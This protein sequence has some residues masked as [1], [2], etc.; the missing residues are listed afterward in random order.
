MSSY[1]PV[2]ISKPTIQQVSLELRDLLAKLSKEAIAQR[3]KFTVAFSGGS[4]PTTVA[5]EL[6]KAT[7]VDFS[8]W[9]VYFADERCC[10]HDHPDSNYLL[11]KD[12]F[13]SK[14]DVPASQVFAINPELVGDPERAAA[15]YA[16]KVKETVPVDNQGMPLFDC[17][18]LGIGPDG[19]TCSLFP[20][21]PQVKVS[22]KIVTHILD[23]PKP[24]PPRITLTLPVLNHARHVAFV[25]TGAGK[26]EMLESIL[27]KRDQSRPSALVSPEH[28]MLFWIL[29]DA[30]AQRLPADLLAKS[31]AVSHL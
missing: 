11:V 30:A 15:D 12:E 8:A 14:V 5:A 1:C 19:H 17:L 18:L 13:L 28:G 24:P 23:S 10:P 27:V 9:Y 2:V 22:D 4:L 3:G 31:S 21:R 29:D 16:A 25:V 26:A 7:D 20:D 6:T